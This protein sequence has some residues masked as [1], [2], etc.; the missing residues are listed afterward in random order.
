MKKTGFVLI[1]IVLLSSCQSGKLVYNVGN[2]WKPAPTV[3]KMTGAKIQI[4]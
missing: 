1:V 4:K 3:S 2:G